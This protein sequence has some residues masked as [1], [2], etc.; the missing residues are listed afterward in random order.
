MDV[1]DPVNS[2]IEALLRRRAGSSGLAGHVRAIEREMRESLHERLRRD[3]RL[4]CQL[5]TGL[6]IPADEFRKKLGDLVR[7]RRTR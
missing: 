6:G 3:K 5:A 4:Q 1:C 2:I 7:N